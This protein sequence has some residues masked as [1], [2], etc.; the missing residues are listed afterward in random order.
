[1]EKNALILGATG[2]IGE[3]IAVSLAKKGYN[4]GIHYGSNEVK[5]EHILEM[6]NDFNVKATLVQAD[7]ADEEEMVRGIK[8][9]ENQIGNID[10]I[11]NTAGI[12]RLSPISDLDMNEFDQIIRTNLRGTFVVA[13]LATQHLK[14]GGV[15]INFSTSITRLQFVEYGAY[16]AAKAAIETLTPILAKELRGKQIRVNTIA[17]GPTATPL[18][19]DGKSDE[20]IQTLSLANPLERLG[21]PEDIAEAVNSVI[22]SKWV[23][24]QVI[25]VNGGMA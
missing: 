3:A 13:K 6:L 22:D 17:P 15:L 19:L 21:T 10:V 25:F 1:M 5:A 12:M 7:V 11:V 23:N 8:D 16:A 18:F 20:L 14:R 9:F 4:I 2:G 24:G